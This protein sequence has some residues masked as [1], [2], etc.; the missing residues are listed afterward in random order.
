MTFISL[1]VQGLEQEKLLRLAAVRVVVFSSQ[2]AAVDE[3]I[4][5]VDSGARVKD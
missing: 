1:H 3:V 2:S 4:V 5:S